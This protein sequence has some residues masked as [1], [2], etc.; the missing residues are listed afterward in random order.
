MHRRH[1]RR[2]VLA[3]I[4]PLVAGAAAC[5]DDQA[6]EEA[7]ALLTR[8]R[9]EGY[10]E[11]DRAPGYETRRPASSP[12]A[13][14]VDIYVNPTVASALVAG[15]LEAWPLGSLIVK[16]GFDGDDLELIAVME[17]RE[18]GWFW[19]EYFGDDSKYSGKPEVCL[20]CHGAGDDHVL[21]FELPR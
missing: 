15:P 19:A 10:R 17:K 21:A 14:Q 4:V 20:D 16:D 11:W 18:D 12:H 5:D 7:A 13:E 9:A 6:P 8:I 3:A 2:L 1:P